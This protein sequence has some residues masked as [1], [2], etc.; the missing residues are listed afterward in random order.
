M[1]TDV[2]LCARLR[3]TVPPENHGW[4]AVLRHPGRTQRQRGSPSHAQSSAVPYLLPEQLP[5]AIFMPRYRY[6]HMVVPLALPH[7]VTCRCSFSQLREGHADCAARTAA[8]TLAS[9]IGERSSPDQ[10]A[11]SAFAACRIT[12]CLI[13]LPCFREPAD[14]RLW[15][16]VQFAFC[17]GGRTEARSARHSTSDAEDCCAGARMTSSRHS[18]PAAT[19]RMAMSAWARPAHGCGRASAANAWQSVADLH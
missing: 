8:D 11:S 17:R 7:C 10:S 14:C 12:C 9:A 4:R 2:L 3:T 19:Q 1:R 15:P 6:V 18:S 13:S 16:S 5:C